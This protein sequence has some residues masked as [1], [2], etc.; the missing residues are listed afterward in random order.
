MSRLRCLRGSLMVGKLPTIRFANPDRY[1]QGRSSLFVRL[2]GEKG[3]RRC[4][5]ADLE[6]MS[7]NRLRTLLCEKTLD[8]LASRIA[9]ARAAYLNEAG[10]QQSFQRLARR[11]YGWLMQQH[12]K[13]T[14]LVKDSW[15]CHMQL[16]DEV[17]PRSQSVGSPM[18]S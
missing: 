3:A 14:N 17:E 18:M 13:F 7:V 4:D 6:V 5:F 16:N 1:T 9:S 15:F 10:M 11:A 2:V 12:L 8:D